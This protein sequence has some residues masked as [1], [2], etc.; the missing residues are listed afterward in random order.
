MN[1]ALKAVLDEI[2]REREYQDA[3]WGVKFDDA[4]TLNDWVAYIM[5][6]AATAT[7]MDASPEKQ[8]RSM[9]KAASLAVAA[10]ETLDR[11]G[12]FAPRHYE[13]RVP[14]GTR[15]VDDPIEIREM[16]PR[17]F[18]VVSIKEEIAIARMAVEQLLNSTKTDEELQQRV[19]SLTT[20]LDLIDRL[21][22]T[23]YKLEQKEAESGTPHPDEYWV[24]Y[25]ETYTYVGVFCNDG[26]GCQ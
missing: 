8:R 25:A 15:P 16:S 2:V 23:A 18:A 9:L 1:T 13:A 5:N 26:S 17:R 12:Q 3:Q 6:Y 21:V 22:R 11:N 4:N 24:S 10:V 14:A 19:P 20:L 7:V